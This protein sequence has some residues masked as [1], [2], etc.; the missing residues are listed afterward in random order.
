[1]QLIIRGVLASLYSQLS[2]PSPFSTY[3]RWLRTSAA[4]PTSPPAGAEWSIYYLSSAS[5]PNPAA[6]RICTTSE[7]TQPSRPS[8]GRCSH[9]RNF[10]NCTP[11]PVAVEKLVLS[12]ASFAGI[13]C[14]FEPT[15]VVGEV[16]TRD[17][18]L[19]LSKIRRTPHPRRLGCSLFEPAPHIWK[20]SP[21]LNN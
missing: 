13:A 17:R 8:R 16:F 19:G 14:D 2:C 7:P 1:M 18:C 5:V 21:G 20:V 11:N 3:P 12:Y 15:T 9:V 10:V 6:Q 4:I